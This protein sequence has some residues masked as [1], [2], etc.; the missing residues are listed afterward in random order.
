MTLKEAFEEYA[1]VPQFKRL[2]GMYRQA[3]SNVFLKKHA[4]VDV[5]EVNLKLVKEIVST[6]DQPDTDKVRACAALVLA[7]HHAHAQGHCSK[8]DFHTDDVFRVAEPSDSEGSK[9]K[10]KPEAKAKRHAELVKRTPKP[11]KKRKKAKPRPVVQLDPKTY[12]PLKTYANAGEA[13]RSVGSTNVLRAVKERIQCAGYFWAYEHDVKDF[14]PNELSLT[15][16]AARFERKAKPALPAPEV[17]EAAI[18]DLDAASDRL[19]E[20]QEE[21]EAER[22]AKAE[23]LAGY[24][25]DEILSEIRRRAK[26]EILAE[27]TNDEILSE[28]RRRKWVGNIIIPQN[29]Q[30]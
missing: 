30:L 4:D 16:R 3:F 10:V 6:S 9:V 5:K 17:I 25:I 2:A 28:I 12:E 21:M 14:K 8:P 20:E 15:H 11:A 26:A 1:K 22:R 27:Y 29:I 18:E 24:T 19:H 7:L 13:G 23:I